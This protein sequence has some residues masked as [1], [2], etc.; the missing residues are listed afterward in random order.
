MGKFIVV[1]DT[2]QM[3]YQIRVRE[4]ER[5][6]LRFIWREF[7]DRGISDCQM[8]VHLFGKVNLPCIANFA[9]T[10]SV[11]DKINTLDPAPAEKI[12]QDF[13]MD[14]SRIFS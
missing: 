5:N 4:I 14:V 10:K 9:L 6:A 1:G 7:P 12:D 13:D 8:T 11:L 2:E 3:F